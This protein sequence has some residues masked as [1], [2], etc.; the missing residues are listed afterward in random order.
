MVGRHVS[1]LSGNRLEVVEAEEEEEK[2]V[3]FD[4][5]DNGA[6]TVTPVG[7]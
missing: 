7:V 1:G 6:T 3:Q 5:C 2:R 4:D